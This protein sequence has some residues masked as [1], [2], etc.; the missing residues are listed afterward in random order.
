M[1][2][3]IPQDKINTTNSLFWRIKNTTLINHWEYAPSGL[4]G[5]N[6]IANGFFMSQMSQKIFWR[7]K[8]IMMIIIIIVNTRMVQKNLICDLKFEL[9][10]SDG[11]QTTNYNGDLTRDGSA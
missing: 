1:N 2:I 10:T 7:T 5:D 11:N 3:S 4:F 6:G 9:I 8:N